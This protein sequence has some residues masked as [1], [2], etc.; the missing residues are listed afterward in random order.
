M[1][2]QDNLKRTYPQILL[3][4]VFLTHN[5]REQWNGNI[6]Q[7]HYWRLYHNSREGA[8]FYLYGKR[9]TMYP[10]KL[11]LL[12]PN[13]LLKNWCDDLP[14]SQLYFHFEVPSLMG[15]QEYP[16][17]ELPLLEE[18]RKLMEQ[19]MQNLHGFNLP[20]RYQ[21]A[22]ISLISLCLSQL[23]DDA[24]HERVA[25]Q[26]IAQLCSQIHTYP[27]DSYSLEMMSK[28][29][30]LELKT[31]Q[32][33]FKKTTGFSPIQY[34]QHVRYTTAARLLRSTDISITDICDFIGIRDRFYFSRQFKIFF[35]LPPSAYHRRFYHVES[36]RPAFR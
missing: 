14:I 15:T 29:V 20:P 35:S 30:G 3:N 36:K 6:P 5:L 17:N 31:F 10:D 26:R 7:A 34:V 33:L 25:D 21:M 9:L 32:R 16:L 11:Y 27:A 22:A 24:L 2:N 1:C 4:E 19:V 28:I 13:C 8:G 18:N 23:P 12:P